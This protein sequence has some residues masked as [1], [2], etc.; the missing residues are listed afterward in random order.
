MLKGLSIAGY[1]GMIGGLL[2]LVLTRNLFS[3]ALFPI[4]AQVAGF[5]LFLWARIHFGRRLIAE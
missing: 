2:A 3:P 4:S 1:L 5:L